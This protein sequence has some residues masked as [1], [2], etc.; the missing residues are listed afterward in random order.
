VIVVLSPAKSLNY[1]PVAGQAPHLAGLANTLPHFVQQP[2]KLVTAAR[3]LSVKK[4]SELMAISDDLAKLNVDRFKAWQPE[5]T[6]ENA[7]QAVL[8]FDGDVY[9]GLQAATLSVDDL[10][11]AQTHLGMLSGLYGVLRP[12]DLMQAYRLEMGSALATKIG[13]AEHKNLYG[14]WGTQITAHLNERLLETK[15]DVIVNLASQEYF[16]SVKTESLNARVIEC[17][18]E[19]EKNGKF[20]VISFFAKQARGLMARF[21]ILNRVTSAAKLKKFNLA[22]YAFAA[23]ASTED[24]L[25]FQRQSPI[26]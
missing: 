11:W 1:A 26:N 21:I 2:L 13:K 7:K 19:D 23:D 22:G 3:K 6:T 10:N 9:T 17:V 5:Y 4:L 16:K 15:S 8:A 18:F 25:V 20:K 12:L 14:F 24:R